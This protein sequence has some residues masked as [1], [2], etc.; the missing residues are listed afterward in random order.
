MDGGATSI[1]NDSALALQGTVAGNLVSDREC[2]VESPT[3]QYLMSPEPP[4]SLIPPMPES[5]LVPCSQMEQ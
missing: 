3:A 1:V 5:I 4:V 2:C